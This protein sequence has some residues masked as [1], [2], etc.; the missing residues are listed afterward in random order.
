MAESSPITT[1]GSP[2]PGHETITTFLVA[3]APLA[4]DPRA[5]RA[6]M[7]TVDGFQVGDV[8]DVPP[9]VDRPG[10]HVVHRVSAR[11]SAPPADVPVRCVQSL[12]AGRPVP[13][14]DC[15]RHPD[16][17]HHLFPFG[18]C[19]RSGSYGPSTMVLIFCRCWQQ[20]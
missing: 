10:L 13:V 18:S 7:H 17:V 4:L 15:P 20:Q 19:L 12:L 2:T 9:G 1:V 11:V 14:A 3:L 6:A 5:V 16:P 8:G